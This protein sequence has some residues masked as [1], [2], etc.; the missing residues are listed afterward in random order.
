MNEQKYFEQFVG[1]VR[2]QTIK[3]NLPE[4]KVPEGSEPVYHDGRLV[5]YISTLTISPWLQEYIK[6]QTK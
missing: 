4:V 3:I 2:K 5:G 1:D 6:Q